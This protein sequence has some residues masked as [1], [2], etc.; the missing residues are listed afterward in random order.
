MKKVFIFL[1]FIS[2]L[3]V[4]INSECQ[5]ENS[6]NIRNPIELELNESNPSHLP[7]EIMYDFNKINSQSKNNPNVISES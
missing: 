7:L 6:D 1:V 2:V 4:K 3:T 5:F